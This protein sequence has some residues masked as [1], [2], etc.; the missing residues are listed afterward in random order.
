MTA[1]PPDFILREIVAR[2]VDED[3]RNGD[4]TTDALFTKPAAATGRIV[5]KEREG[6]VLA[7]VSVV[8]DALKQV[9][10]GLS[11]AMRA[12]DGDRLLE[13]PTLLPVSGVARSF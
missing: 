6:I 7:G 4:V 12:F 3:L 9:A 13:S 5:G 1:S 11:G 10:A 2:A 8:A